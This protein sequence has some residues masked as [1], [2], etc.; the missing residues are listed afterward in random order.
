[1]LL[2]VTVC[3]LN[4]DEGADVKFW[5]LPVPGTQAIFTFHFGFS[6][7]TTKLPA[8]ASYSCGL[9]TEAPNSV[10]A[11]SMPQEFI[12]VVVGGE[13][14]KFLVCEQHPACDM[15]ASP[16]SSKFENWPGLVL[17]ISGAGQLFCQGCCPTSPQ[18]RA[19]N[20][21]ET[22]ALGRDCAARH[23]PQQ[24]HRQRCVADR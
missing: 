22:A 15:R 19:L 6:K 14:S 7:E 4:N 21:D 17:A 9:Y 8:H 11:P 20:R 18:T 16:V 5:Y 1:M 13:F 23:R 3:V 2:R 10:E 12:G 24:T